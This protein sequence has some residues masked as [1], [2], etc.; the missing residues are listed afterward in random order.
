MSIF[1]GLAQSLSASVR[2]FP[3]ISLGFGKGTYRNK[4]EIKV[5]AV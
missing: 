3:F 5:D 1:Q 4:P 2:R